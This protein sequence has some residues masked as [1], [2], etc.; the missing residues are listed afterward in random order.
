MATTRSQKNK[1]K[2]GKI[3][4]TSCISVT[5]KNTSQID[6]DEVDIS[7]DLRNKLA[8]S[9]FEIGELKERALQ[10]EENELKLQRTESNRVTKQ[11][12]AEQISS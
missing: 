8:T 5:H 10:Y 11:P 12:F 2:N 4:N 1:T 7:S 3:L 9:C 6:V